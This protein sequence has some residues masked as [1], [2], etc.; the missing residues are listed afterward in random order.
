MRTTSIL[1]P[2]ENPS[3]QSSTF[4]SLDQSRHQQSQIGIK[5]LF[6]QSSLK[7]KRNG[8]SLEYCISRS[9]EENYHIWWSGKVSVKTQ[10]DI[11]GNQPKTSGVSLNL[12]R[13]FTLCILT[14]QEQIIEELELIYG[15]LWGE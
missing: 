1:H 3:S 11:P 8:K 15:A 6:L 2:N 7:K 14:I 13:T 12:S 10:K 5:S 9:R 4:P